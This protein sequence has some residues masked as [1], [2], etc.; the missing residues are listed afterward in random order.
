VNETTTFELTG[1][2]LATVAQ[3]ADDE[4][5]TLAQALAL[6]IDQ[7]S[8]PISRG[9]LL[10]GE[11]GKDLLGDVFQAPSAQHPVRTHRTATTDDVAEA[12][13]LVNEVRSA[14]Q[15]HLDE[16]GESDSFPYEQVETSYALDA[17]EEVYPGSPTTEDLTWDL[18]FPNGDTLHLV[19]TLA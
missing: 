1:S 7:A 2:T 10:G 6:I 12:I 15:D 17:L 4:G 5:V 11:S 9:L 8:D 16:A 14:W 19:F 18:T 13:D 3:L